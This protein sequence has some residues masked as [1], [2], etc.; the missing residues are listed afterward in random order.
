[1]PALHW[2]PI[3]AR[4]SAPL[5]S[6]AVGKGLSDD[7]VS[8][9]FNDPNQVAHCANERRSTRFHRTNAP[10]VGEVVEAIIGVSRPFWFYK[11]EIPSEPIS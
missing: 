10:A 6:A 1:M 8:L 5:G 9:D 2:L 3:L 7:M 11:A 4:S